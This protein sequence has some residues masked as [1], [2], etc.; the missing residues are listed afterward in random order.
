MDSM[1]KNMDINNGYKWIVWI[2]I[3]QSITLII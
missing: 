2:R 3:L 1:D